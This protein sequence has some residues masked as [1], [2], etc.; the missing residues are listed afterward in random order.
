MNDFTHFTPTAPKA[1][2]CEFQARRLASPSHLARESLGN[3]VESA[4]RRP[5]ILPLVACLIAM[6]GLALTAGCASAANGGPSD[7]ASVEISN[8]TTDEIR[9]ETVAVFTE[10]GYVAKV[11]GNTRMVFETM[12]SFSDN[13][14]YGGWSPG[15]VSIRV[16]L[17][18]ESSGATAYRVSCQASMVRNSGDSVFE[19]EQKL[20]R[21]RRRPFQ[22]MLDEI[23]TRVEQPE[24]STDAT[25]E[26]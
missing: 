13:L 26:S 8:H 5:P 3:Q 10:K 7:F 21:P 19:D 11:A 18:I 4:D 1:A 23:K 2:L 24:P 14:W 16:N 9:Q 20:L 22:D 12:G 15:E 17:N 25:T 6:V